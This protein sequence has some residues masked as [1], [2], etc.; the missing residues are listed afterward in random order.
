MF[1][2]LAA[3]IIGGVF[4]SSPVIIGGVVC[5]LLGAFVS[6]FSTRKRKI[7]NF[8]ETTPDLDNTSTQ[9]MEENQVKIDNKIN[10]STKE[11]EKGNF[12]EKEKALS[13]TNNKQTNTN[14]NV[15]PYCGATL[16]GVSLTCDYCGGKL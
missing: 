7:A 13:E 14:S 10:N 11:V 5:G 9:E 3:L 12:N 6:T 4:S 16:S 2:G 15:C 1:V 8:I